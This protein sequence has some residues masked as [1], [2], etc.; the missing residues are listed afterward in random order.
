MMQQSLE[1]IDR[2]VKRM[3]VMLQDLVDVTRLES[4]QFL[5]KCEAVNLPR[6]LD[7]LLQQV[8]MVLEI[9]RI[10]VD[11]PDD[12]PSVS[13]DYARLERILVN[14]LSNALKYSNPDTPVRVQA[15]LQDN[16]VVIAVTDQ[17]RG[18]PPK[19]IPH[20]FER[21]YRIPSERKAEGIGLGLYITRVL[22]EAHGG[23]I[24]VE[25]TVDKGS[26]FSFTLPVAKHFPG[27]SNPPVLEASKVS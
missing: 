7:D 18:I 4:G 5:L 8:R 1:A 21:F 10:Q 2:S 23:Q 3:D 26:I 19:V 11:I 20:L 6:Y 27:S 15:K 13:A 9:T 16:A 12:L 17:G 25:S 14:L 22:V 24:R